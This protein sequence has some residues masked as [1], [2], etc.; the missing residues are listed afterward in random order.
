M[1]GYGSNEGEDE[2]RV[3]FWNDMDRILDTVGNRYR[4]RI[5]RDLNGW[6]EDRKQAG[7][8]GVFGVTGMIMVEEWWISVL[9]GVYVYC[10]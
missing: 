3:R 5:L 9:K 1:V 6:T 10:R 4:L 2:N 8:T 7:I